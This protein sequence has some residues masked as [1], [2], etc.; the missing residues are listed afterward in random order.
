MSPYAYGASRR[1]PEVAG[2]SPPRFRVQWRL[3]PGERRSVVP[4]SLRSQRLDD[5]HRGVDRAS[6]SSR[7]RYETLKVR[8]LLLRGDYRA[9]VALHIL[10]FCLT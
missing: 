10:T 6:P 4:V 7:E 1:F 9:D 8:F 5:E 2:M 3:G